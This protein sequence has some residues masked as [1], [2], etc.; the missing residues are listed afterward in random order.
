MTR[1]TS[2][3]ALLR[4][5]LAKLKGGLRR[6]PA[7]FSAHEHMSRTILDTL[8]VCVMLLDRDGR[9]LEINRGGLA[10]LEADHPAQLLGCCA[11]ELVLPAYREPMRALLNQ[12]FDG[13]GGQLR[14]EI[15]GIKG[16]PLW[17]ESHAVPLRG[18]D[19]A[20]TAQLALIRDIGAEKAMANTLA[21]KEVLVREVH[22]RVRDNLQVISSLL[23]LQAERMDIPSAREALRTAQ[24]RVHA[25]A[26]AHEKLCQSGDLVLVDFD[27][28]IT[29]LVHAIARGQGRGDLS[30]KVA[31]QGV[32]LDV[33]TATC[34]G[35]IVNELVQNAFKHA[36]PTSGGVISVSLRRNGDACVLAVDDDGCGLAADF[37]PARIRSLGLR[38]VSR[39][40]GQLGGTLHWSHGGGTRFEVSFSARRKE[41]RS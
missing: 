25:M 12:V 6:P 8:P 13:E 27:A 39:L 9:V 7:A 32:H 34:C 20:I 18:P 4:A 30:L 10:T 24:G 26:L 21:A 31:A 38:L 41:H 19:G 29:G 14:F 28:Y 2:R 11:P 3:L 15:V 37:D 22:R 35:L 1:P 23:N 16:S 40:A 33:D 5:G 36:F 17:L